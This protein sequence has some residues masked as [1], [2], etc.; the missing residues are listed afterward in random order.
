LRFPDKP[1]VSKE[2]RDL[3]EKLLCEPEN[4]LGSIR[5][6]SQEEDS[7]N[8]DS[9]GFTSISFSVSNTGNFGG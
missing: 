4:R 1:K 9:D 3:I 8:E 2:A 7:I 6:S 5:T